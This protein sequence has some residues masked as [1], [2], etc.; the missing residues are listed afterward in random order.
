M[1]R[2]S[3]YDRISEKR[4]QEEQLERERLAKEAMKPPPPERYLTNELSFVRPQALRDKTFHVF[5][6]TESAPSP[7]SLVLGRSL[8]GQDASLESL[9]QKLL[10]E[11]EK[12]LSHL[13][14]VEPVTSIEVAGLDARRVAFSW[15][16]Q[17]QPVHQIQVMFLHKDEHGQRLLMQFTAT[18]NHTAGMKEEERSAFAEIIN[19]LELR[20]PP[21]AKQKVVEAAPA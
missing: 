7:F 15:R 16:Q 12:T 1:Y 5:T 6:L 10:G 21:T 19:S 4:E 13:Q 18:S 9:A 20:S 8:A 3:I 2:K 17:G 14:W 11:M